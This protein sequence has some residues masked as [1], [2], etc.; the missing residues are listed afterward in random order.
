[1][2]VVS[3]LQTRRSCQCFCAAGGSI[4][5][6]C[7]KRVTAWPRALCREDQGW[8]SKN[9]GLLCNLRRA[10][11]PWASPWKACRV[12]QQLNDLSRLMELFSIVRQMLEDVCQEEQAWF[13][14]CCASSQ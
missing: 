8:G 3:A 2:H 5:P 7:V 12:P 9:V 14:P 13:G 6:V 1:M 4:P 10:V 11:S